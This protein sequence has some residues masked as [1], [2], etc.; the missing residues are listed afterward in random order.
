MLSRIFKSKGRFDQ[1]DPGIRRQAVEELS[2]AK[3]ESLQEDLL[4]LAASDEDP[5]VRKACIAKLTS[6]EG[7]AGLLD[8]PLSA[9]AAAHRIVELLGADA[10]N[11]LARHPLVLKLRLLEMTPAEAEP[12]LANVTDTDL[13]I[14]LGIRARH[15]L[16]EVIL[17][18]LQT[19]AAL[20]ELEHQTRGHDKFLNRY[21]RESLERIRSTRRE[22][23]ETRARLVALAGALER[24]QRVD[25][26]PSATQRRTGLLREF[27]QASARFEAL[28][29]ELRAVGEDVD[30]ID[31]ARR[32][33]A[34]VREQAPVQPPPEQPPAEVVEDPFPTLVAAFQTLHQ[35]MADGKDFAVISSERQALTDK[36]LSAAD[37]V[38]PSAA[39]HQVFEEIS[40]AYRELADSIAQISGKPW[41]GF[42]LEPLAETFPDD[43]EQ[44]RSLW[45]QVAERKRALRHGERMIEAAAWPEWAKP[46]SQYAELL[47]GI[48][49]IEQELARAQAHEQS[50]KSR[51]EELIRALTAEIEEGAFKAAF[52]T[53]NQARRLSKALPENDV[54]KLV[55]AL[56]HEAARLAELRDWQTFATTPKREAL[57]EAIQALVDRPF[58]PPD[59]A[60]RI[61]R[62]RSEWNELG[63]VSRSDDRKLADHFNALAEKAFEPCR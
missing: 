61:K 40:H 13:L 53:L 47:L 16:R 10:S 9:D 45:R 24:H 56:N 44:L 28:A 42:G 23:Q 3:A 38:Q 12:E 33:V 54:A 60:D 20:T 11:L 58:D 31:A 2:P 27:E 48:N 49:R 25:V 19:T 43:S 46:D 26:D 1:P 22:A 4:A 63:P 14:E 34:T 35:S 41:S 59:Q 6:T 51:L 37:H 50:L 5:G 30:A 52:A 17:Q 21:A 18:R 32:Q 57:C 29:Q 15:D 36:W 39:D 8:D 62:L 7:V 55:K